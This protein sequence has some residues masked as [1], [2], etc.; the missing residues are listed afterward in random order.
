MCLFSPSLHLAEVFLLHSHTHEAGLRT[1]GVK[2]QSR[3]GDI[4]MKNRILINLMHVWK[5][6][7]WRLKTVFSGRSPCRDGGG[8]TTTRHTRLFFLLSLFFFKAAVCVLV[9]TGNVLFLWKLIMINWNFQVG[10]NKT[11]KY[12]ICRNGVGLFAIWAKTEISSLEKRL[13]HLKGRQKP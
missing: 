9:Y 8:W 1:V 13:Q 6:L 7:D 4:C 12:E 5:G 2:T 3:H 10:T 11:Q